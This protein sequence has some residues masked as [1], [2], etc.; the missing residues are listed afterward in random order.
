MQ[1]FR[2]PFRTAQLCVLA[3]IWN[4]IGD[5]QSEFFVMTFRILSL[6]FNF[7]SFTVCLG[8]NL[9]FFAFRGHYQSVVSW[10]SS[11]WK[12]L[13]IISS[14]IV[15]VPY[16]PFY[17]SSYIPKLFLPQ[18]FCLLWF[19]FQ[20]V[21]SQVFAGFTL[22]WSL[23]ELHCIRVP[24]WQSYLKYH[25]FLTSVLLP[26]LIPFIVSIISTSYIFSCSFVSY[27]IFLKSKSNEDFFSIFS[28][29]YQVLKI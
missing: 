12:F 22:F 15:S 8:V 26:A 27:L 25:S 3:S 5:K 23:H 10:F 13:F 2:L 16:R 21:F 14:N 4:F 1:F 9:Y 24:L 20:R 28:L 17:C 29:L 19:C 6:L 11:F 18:T 7:F